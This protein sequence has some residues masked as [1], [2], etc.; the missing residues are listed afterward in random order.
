MGQVLGTNH[1]A[2]M[3]KVRM[4]EEESIKG[5]GDNERGGSKSREK[6]YSNQETKL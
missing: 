6:H 2:C 1:L 3:W 4:K 5:E